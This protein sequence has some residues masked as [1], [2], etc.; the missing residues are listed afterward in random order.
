M[1]HNIDCIDGMYS[2]QDKADLI[3]ADPPFNIGYEYDFYSDR[4]VG[5]DYVA[6]SRR[7]LRAAYQALSPTGT[8]WIAIGDDYAAELKIAAETVGFH[9]RSW[10]IWHYTFGVNCKNKLTRAHTHL[11]YM[12]KDRKAF[13][14]NAD[15][16]R[17][18]SARQT[19]YNDKR[20]MAGGRLPDDV[21]QFNRVCGTHRERV[22]WHPCQMPES[23]LDRILRACSSEG[24]T[25]LDPFSGSGTTGV[26]ASRLGRNFIGFELSPEYCRL[27]TERIESATPD[28]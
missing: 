9:M 16:I 1:I 18:P 4:L 11:F 13:T 10:V 24:D 7:W 14:F 27:A 19:K 23:I 2:L 20:A 22:K 3:F 6:W 26:V 8:L 15:A 25:V 5:E 28:R 12:V 17:V 21:W